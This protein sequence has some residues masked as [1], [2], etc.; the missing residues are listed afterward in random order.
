MV[1]KRVWMVCVAYLVD[2]VVAYLSNTSSGLGWTLSRVPNSWVAAGCSAG[3]LFA[4]PVVVVVGVA[5]VVVG[6]AG[7]L[8]AVAA[9]PFPIVTVGGA[10]TLDGM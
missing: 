8:V 6:D 9:A 3:M 2:G 5:V 4:V 10:G 1:A 7:V